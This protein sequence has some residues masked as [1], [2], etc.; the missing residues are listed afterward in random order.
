MRVQ[1][2]REGSCCAITMLIL[3]LLRAQ[4]YGAIIDAAPRA[5]SSMRVAR[6]RYADADR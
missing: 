2:T 6:V 4:R 3:T 1:L 5:A